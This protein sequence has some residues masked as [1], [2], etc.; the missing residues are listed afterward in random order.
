MKGTYHPVSVRAQAVALMAHGIDINEV[1]ADTG[2]SRTAILFW[3]KKAKERGFNPNINRHV[4]WM[5]K[6]CAGREKSVEFLGYE[7][8]LTDEMKKK[9]LDFYLKLQDWGLEKLKDI[10]S[11]GIVLGHRRGSQKV[12]RTFADVSNPTVIRRH[13]KGVTE[14]MVWACFT[15][16]KEGPIYIW[17][18]ETAQDKKLADI[19]IA[20]LNEE[21]EPIKKTEWELN[22]GLTRVQLRSGKTPGRVPQ[23]RWNKKNRK[24]VR[25]SK[26]G[27][28]WW[29]YQKVELFKYLADSITY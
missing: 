2:M 13:W 14:F 24:L 26:G 28:D 12:W 29:R 27:I 22:T 9:R 7:A 18:T 15:Y 1:M 17:K 20:K 10:I 5:T 8:G 25:E 16:D 6:D 11:T 19:E 3:V 23:W 21:L 4:L